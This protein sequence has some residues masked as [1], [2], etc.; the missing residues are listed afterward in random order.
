MLG[1]VLARFLFLKLLLRICIRSCRWCS[2]ALS[3]RLHIRLVR[4]LRSLFILRAGAL[5]CLIL[6]S[7]FLGILLFGIL[8]LG[9]AVLRMFLIVLLLSTLLLGVL[10]LCILLLLL[11]FEVL[12]RFCILL[13]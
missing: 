11:G 7:F 8:L 10:L 3:N 12:L 9:I 2:F 6:R 1:I 13:L 5:T 4:N